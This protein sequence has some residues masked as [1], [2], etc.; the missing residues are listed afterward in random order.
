MPSNTSSSTNADWWKQEK[1]WAD[2][3][4]T[5]S[6]KKGLYGLWGFCLVWNGFVGIMVFS[7]YEQFIQEVN[8]EPMAAIALLFPLVGIGMLYSAIKQTKAWLALGPT[9]LCL[10]PFPGS[11]GGHVGGLIDT[12]ISYNANNRFEVTLSCC[13]SYI[14][15]SGKDR[16]RKESVVWQ[17]E[18]FCQPEVGPQGTRL[19]FRFDVPDNLPESDPKNQERYHL[20]RLSLSATLDGPDLNRSFEIPVFKTG[21]QSASIEQCSIQHQHMQERAEEGIYSI[22]NINNI[23]DGIELYFP[24]FQRPSFGISFSVFGLIFV[25]AGLFAGHHGAPSIFPIVFTLIGGLFT[26]AG[27]FYLAK[28]LRVQATSNGIR[29]RRY[30][31]GYPITSKYLAKDELN[32]IEIKK[33]GSSQSGTKTTVIYNLIAHGKDGSKLVLAERLNLRAEA[34]KLKELLETY[35]GV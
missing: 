16:K 7:S 6:A 17:T 9:P 12:N 29:T 34:D 35:L 14:S 2:N 27:I 25:A 23:A 28:S 20:W 10:D 30:L 1:N 32:N 11:I 13:K 15:G 19:S 3:H 4:I 24:A 31:F 22:A 21:T 8:K 5:S 18:G 33:K 26:L